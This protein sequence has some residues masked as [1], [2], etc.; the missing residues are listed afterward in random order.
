M[1]FEVFHGGDVSSRILM[2]CDAV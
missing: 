2:D 1:S